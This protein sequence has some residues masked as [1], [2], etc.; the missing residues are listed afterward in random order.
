MFT[1]SAEFRGAVFHSYTAV[2]GADLYPAIGDT[3]YD[4]PVTDGEVRVDASAAVRRV[5]NNL[6][7]ASPDLLPSD[8]KNPA[9]PYG[10]EIRPWRGIRFPN[11]HIEKVPLGVFRITDADINDDGT[12]GLVV[13]GSDRSRVISRNRFTQPYVIAAGQN[14]AT[15]IGTLVSDRLPGADIL[16]ADT[17]ETTPLLVFDVE[18][19]PWTHLQDMAKSF[20]HECLFDANGT[21]VLRPQTD[22]SDEQP[23][24]WY[25]EGVNSVLLSIDRS[26]SDEPG[27]NGVL[28]RAE[29]TT[30]P[31]PIQS[32]IW[33]MDPS[34]PTFADGPY[35]R[36]P[37][38][39]TSPYI[40]SQTACDT[41]ARAWLVRNIGGTDNVSFSIVPN[42]ALD[43]GDVVGI[44]RQ[45]AHLERAGV[46]ES[47]SVPLSAT[48]SMALT[49]R[50]RQLLVDA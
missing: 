33:D 18:D 5:L 46:V 19:D 2:S 1:T 13:N 3:L 47:L 29:S 21:F 7:I 14:Y 45:L 35:G 6:Q 48:E 4:L 11:G 50:S 22:P 41:A 44:S 49:M 27:Y 39:Q 24:A 37:A 20:G 12:P 43:A 36:V 28:M 40:N 32:L 17:D 34:S 23:V 15:A 38:F 30:L 31:Q 16:L 8:A 26:L 42:P 10:S 9:A 25:A